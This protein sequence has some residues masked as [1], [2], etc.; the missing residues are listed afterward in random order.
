MSRSVEYYRSAECLPW[1]YDLYFPQIIQTRENNWNYSS[2][3][4]INW[5]QCQFSFL[6]LQKTTKNLMWYIVFNFHFLALKMIEIFCS[7]SIPID[8]DIIRG[9][10][11]WVFRGAVEWNSVR[12]RNYLNVLQGKK[13]CF[14][15]YFRNRKLYLESQDDNKFGRMLT[16]CGT[17]LR[18]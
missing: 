6:L 7:E 16:S 9:Y 18:T 4:C 11:W 13:K 12:L 5:S 10:L 3:H 15:H 2:I 8:L 17:L 14:F 1:M